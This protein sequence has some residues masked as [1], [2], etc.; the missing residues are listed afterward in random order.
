MKKIVLFLTF[1][2][3]SNACSLDDDRTSYYF[4]NLPIESVEVPEN[5]VMGKTYEMKVFYKRPTTCHVFQGFYYNSELNERTVAVQTAV[6]GRNDCKSLNEEPIQASF[7]FTVIN[8][9]TYI[10]KFFQ[11]RDETGKNKFLEIEIPVVE[12]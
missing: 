1:L 12:E 4:E 7:N 5:F 9:G 10:F 8:N 6:Y 11:G 3:V 2:F